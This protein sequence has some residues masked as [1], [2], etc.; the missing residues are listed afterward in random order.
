MRPVFERGDPLGSTG[1][2]VGMTQSVSARHHLDTQGL[3][4]TP[5]EPT[6]PCQ[7]C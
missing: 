2:G 3:K 5:E 6:T 1:P 4:K 7:I